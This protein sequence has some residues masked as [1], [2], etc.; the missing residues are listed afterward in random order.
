[1]R[2]L[3][4]GDP[5]PLPEPV[6]SPP[7]EPLSEAATP[8]LPE[9]SPEPTPPEPLA[10]IVNDCIERI[11]TLGP[12]RTPSAAP[13]RRGWRRKRDQRRE[14]RLARRRAAA[15]S[16][17]VAAGGVSWT[18]I[19]GWLHLAPR[20][21]RSWRRLNADTPPK[22]LGRPLQRSPRELRNEVIHLLDTVGPHLGVP[23]LR[24]HFPTM[25]RAELAD[26]VRRYRRVWR[27]RNRQP[28]HILDWTTPGRVWAIDFAEAPTPVDGRYPY[29]L[30]VRDLSSGMQLL[31]QPVEAATAEAARAGLDRLFVLH[32][33]PLVLKC[34]NGSP[35][36]ATAVQD[37]LGRHGVVTL[38][39]PPLTPRYNGGIE[40]GIGSLKE[41]THAA[42]ARAG[43][44]GFWT[45]DDLAGAQSQANVT[46]RPRGPDGPGPESIWQSRTPIEGPER[47]L[48]G[49][50]LRKALAEEK[51][52]DSA[53]EA[54]AG[55]VWSERAMARVAIRRT[56]ET[57]GYLT[58]RRRRIPPP[59]TR[60]KAANNT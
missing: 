22:L 40:A 29:L 37:F 45:G 48:F 4:T 30:A 53:C 36:A 7:S 42:A 19:A 35:F 1:L 10:A 38:F 16:Q 12:V 8:P 34:D 15:A 60:P 39:S 33:P 50:R 44:P 31:W 57:C 52:C 21:L 49:S 54:T 2:E 27:K 17:R 26:L 25:A 32:A 55:E 51:N 56:L 14:E 9:P 43:H 59:I 3:P 18:K 24:E 23:G 58:Y 6:S 20:T 11:E 13:A 5:D 28:L 41:R 47:E 46:A